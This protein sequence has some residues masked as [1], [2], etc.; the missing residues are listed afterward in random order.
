MPLEKFKLYNSP[1]ETLKQW[2]RTLNYL[3]D[4]NLDNTNIASTGLT[5]GTTAIK[6][7]NIDFGLDANEVDAS[8]IPITDAGGYFAG[9]EIEN[10]LQQLG[11]TV[12][13]LPAE[14]S[15]ID[16]TGGYYDSTSVEG[17][18]Q[19]LG[20]TLL[21]IPAENVKI[22]DTG[23]YYTSTSVEGALQELG[24]TILNL[25][26]ENVKIDDTGGYYTSTSVEGVLQE[27]GDFVT[28]TTDIGNDLSTA[29]TGSTVLTDPLATATELNATNTLV[30]E[31]KQILINLGIATTSI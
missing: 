27:I 6:A 9:G 24:S 1:E 28:F 29:V 2:A 21:N 10:A 11:S 12:L 13:N 19:E 22:D 4:R 25:P 18:L 8:D 23:G 31:I 26:A 5:V 7:S 16:D 14:N 17:A 3:L 30:N 15:K 20:S